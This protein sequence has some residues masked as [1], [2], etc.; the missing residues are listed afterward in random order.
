MKSADARTAA[1]RLVA[2]L[3]EE[4][5]IGNDEIDAA[6]AHV[7]TVAECGHR[8][9]QHVA[10]DLAAELAGKVAPPACFSSPDTLEAWAAGAQGAASARATLRRKLTEAITILDSDGNPQLAAEL[11]N[12]ARAALPEEA[13]PA[14]APP[15]RPVR[16]DAEGFPAEWSEKR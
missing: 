1:V 11:H 9:G 8:E 15:A 14:A 16:L 7:A 4:W 12:A 5:M 13:A 6:L 3:C 2:L 10:F